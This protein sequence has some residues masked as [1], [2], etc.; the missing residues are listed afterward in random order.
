MNEKNEVT[1]DSL[2]IELARLRRLKN[3]VTLMARM[4]Q[5][6]W[7]D[8]RKKWGDIDSLAIELARLL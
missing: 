3:E 6:D 1:F 4:H 8:E 2:A 7:S 5:Q